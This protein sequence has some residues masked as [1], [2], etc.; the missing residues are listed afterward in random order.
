M[1][2]MKYVKQIERLM[3]FVLF[4]DL[5]SLTVKM[6]IDSKDNVKLYFQPSSF[7][8]PQHLFERSKWVSGIFLLLW[9]CEKKSLKS[10]IIELL[11]FWIIAHAKTS[12]SIN[13]ATKI[14]SQLNERARLAREHEIILI[15]TWKH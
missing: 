3:K 5:V 2:S 4:S 8:L 10:S 15:P 12:R 7:L 1:A 6:V 11:C 9:I 14:T 13:V